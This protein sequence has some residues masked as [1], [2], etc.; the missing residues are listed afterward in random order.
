MNKIL[1]QQE[2]SKVLEPHLPTIRKC[3]LEALDDLNKA[4]S[5]ISESLNNRAKCSTLHSIATEKAKR[6]FKDTPGIIVKSKYQSIQIVFN[7]LLVGRIKKVNSD[8]MSQNAKT[9]RN[10][11]ILTHQLSLFPDI[12]QL[13]FIDLGYNVIPTWSEFDKLLVVCR[14]NDKIEWHIDYKETAIVKS[15]TSVEIQTPK[16]KE[17]QIKIKKGGKIV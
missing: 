16:P 12:P 13:T 10:T 11:N 5:V 9:I 14:F 1:S 8:K 2:A 3:M 15:I 17:E 7:Q 4:M 6:Y